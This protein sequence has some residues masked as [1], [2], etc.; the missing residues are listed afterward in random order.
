MPVL[1]NVNEELLIRRLTTL[2]MATDGNC[3]V[4]QL[5]FRGFG[6]CRRPPLLSISPPSGSPIL[7]YRHLLHM[8]NLAAICALVVAYSTTC[9]LP[10]HSVPSAFSPYIASVANLSLYIL[11]ITFSP[12]CISA[13]CLL[14]SIGIKSA[15]DGFW[16]T[17]ISLTTPFYRVAVLKQRRVPDCHMVRWENAVLTYT[18]GIVTIAR[19]AAFG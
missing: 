1:R 5:Y 16:Q 15:T 6:A 12:Y 14:F 9:Q 8:W 13:A 2:S 7:L 17:R 19:R 10:C 11:S 4:L 3:G 18:A